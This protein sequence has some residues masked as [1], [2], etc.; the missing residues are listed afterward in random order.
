[1]IDGISALSI[2]TSA[3]TDPAQRAALDSLLT[4]IQGQVN[5]LISSL[6][7]NIQTSATGTRIVLTSPVATPAAGQVGAGN[8]NWTMVGNPSL[9]VNTWGDGGGGGTR[10]AKVASGQV[11]LI[12]DVVAG[13]SSIINQRIFTLPTNARLKTGPIFFFGVDVTSGAMVAFQAVAS[14]VVEMSVGA[15]TS[16]HEYIGITSFSAE[17]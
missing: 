11:E 12:M 8:A 10:F 3:W 1:M 6:G 13:A 4:Q 7:T 9:Y 16:G 17:Q 15:V 2:D 14:G 5:A